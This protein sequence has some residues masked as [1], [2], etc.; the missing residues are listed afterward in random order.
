MR[1]T[2]RIVLSV[3]AV[4]L[5]A[6]SAIVYVKAGEIA[7]HE[8]AR[9][10]R[11]RY[12][13]DADV[14]SANVGLDGVSLRGIRLALPSF[15]GAVVEVGEVELHGQLFRLLTRRL[16]GVERIEAHAVHVDVRL[17]DR[18]IEAIA[19]ARSGE[20]GRAVPSSGSSGR[21]RPLTIDGISLSLE[22][23]QGGLARVDIDE[24]RVDGTM[25]GMHVSRVELG[26]ADADRLIAEGIDVDFDFTDGKRVRR[27]HAATVGAHWADLGASADSRLVVRLRG[28][29]QRMRRALRRPGAS[30]ESS[31]ESLLDRYTTRDFACSF[32]RASLEAGDGASATRMSLESGQLRR[33]DARR[34]ALTGR[35]SGDRG[36]ALRFDLRMDPV[37]K[38]A[39]GTVV[40]RKVPIALLGPLI[41]SIPFEATMPGLVSV[42]VSLVAESPDRVSFRGALDVE[43]AALSSERLA[44]HP[45]RDLGFRVEGEGRYTVPER[46]LELGAA[47]LTMGGTS[48]EW[49]GAVVASPTERRI[50]G[51][52]RLPQTSCDRAVHAIPADVLGPLREFQL[53]GTLE[54]RIDVALDLA[55]LNATR[56][57]VAVVDGCTFLAAPAMADVAQFEGPFHHQV[58]EPDGSVFSMDTGP[59]TWR[60]VPYG[61]ISSYVVDAV[62]SHEDGAFERHGGFAPWAIRDAIV[63]NLREGR[64]VVG[65]STITMQLA[66]NLFLNRE[67]HLVRKVQEVLLTWWLERSLDKHRILELYLNVIEFGPG[68]YGLRAASRYYFGC[69]PSAITPVGAALLALVLPAP[70]RLAPS[71]D[72]PLSE[73]LRGRILRFLTHMAGQGRIDAETLAAAEV[74]VGTFRFREPPQGPQLAH[75]EDEELPGEDPD[76]PAFAP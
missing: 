46:R 53:E 44:P 12:G 7:A 1:R 33:I 74:E 20:P 6:L 36:E 54:G 23:E 29:A 67:K 35:G 17:D 71:P 8:A 49:R 51:T 15:D 10:L 69:D 43:G 68:I 18:L 45:L 9:A 26:S 4:L 61:R 5:G 27:V 32:D 55:D 39:E 25:V 37:A 34:I 59:G 65:A 16:A 48:L 58:T 30:P 19:H 63:R 57:E 14:S 73:G 21:T 13:V 31:E 70:K 76:D 22:D 75:D 3:V 41:P 60:W 2:V 64:Y 72:G 24:A 40:L 56:F 50:A 38:A 28:A 11:T 66:K 47:R 62:L 52:L 42:D